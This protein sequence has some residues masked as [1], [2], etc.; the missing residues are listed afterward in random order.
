M[1]AG[2]G[3]GVGVVVGDVW[4]ESRQAIQHQN[5]LQAAVEQHAADKRLQ[6]MHLDKSEAELRTLRNTIEPS[7]HKTAQLLANVCLCLRLRLRLCLC[8]CLCLCLFVCLFVC[9]CFFLCVC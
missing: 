5:E 8:L 3:V 4:G 7:H 2:V 6:L 9:V 1:C